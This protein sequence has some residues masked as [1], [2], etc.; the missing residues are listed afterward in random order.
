MAKYFIASLLVL[1]F[2]IIILHIAVNLFSYMLIIGFFIL[3]P[4]HSR[5]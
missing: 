5:C 1:V 3:K 4:L 2:F